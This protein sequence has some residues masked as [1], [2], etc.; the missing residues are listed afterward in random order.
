MFS[1]R[2]ADDVFPRQTLDRWGFDI[3][4]LAIAQSRGFRICEIPIT[5]INA[6][7][8]KVTLSTYLEVL[9]EI[10]S[11]RRNLKAGLYQ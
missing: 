11:I 10:R 4:L 7:G 9:G 1:A 2:A 3:E 5:W 8:S 6:P